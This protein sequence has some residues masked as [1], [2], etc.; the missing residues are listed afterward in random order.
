MGTKLLYVKELFWIDSLDPLQLK[1]LNVS[2]MSMLCCNCPLRQQIRIHNSQ[3]THFL[4]EGEEVRLFFFKFRKQFFSNFF[5][6][7][8]NYE[9]MSLYLLFHSGHTFVWFFL[10][11][12]F[13][14]N[15]F[16]SL[17]LYVVWVCLFGN[18]LLGLC[19]GPIEILGLVILTFQ[20]NDFLNFCFP[21][22]AIFLL[23]ISVNLFYL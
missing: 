7:E 15:L 16:P 10:A 20:F 14:S 19:I 11:I 9:K 17:S 5:V 12:V 22:F 4:W 6:F 1:D 23:I 3:E 2:L 8:V 13:Y 21:P 18:V